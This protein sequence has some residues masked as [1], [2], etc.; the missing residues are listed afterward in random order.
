MMC[1]I[2]EFP[3]QQMKTSPERSYGTFTTHLR[4]VCNIEELLSPVG[5]VLCYHHARHDKHSVSDAQRIPDYFKEM[6]QEDW[7]V[8]PDE[9][10]RST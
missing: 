8:S 10:F 5:L 1:H 3:Q 2:D 9:P 6:T 4:A 7:V